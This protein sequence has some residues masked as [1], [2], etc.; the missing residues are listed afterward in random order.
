MTVEGSKVVPQTAA[1]EFL[2]T[3]WWWSESS[4]CLQRK[5]QNCYQKEGLH[6][7]SAVAT[8]YLQTMSKFISR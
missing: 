2:F 4:G 7:N 1:G 5:G 3:S 8:W 6:E